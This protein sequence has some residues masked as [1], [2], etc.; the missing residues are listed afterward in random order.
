MPGIVVGVDGSDQSRAALRWAMHEAAQHHLPLTVITVRPAP[1][2]PATGIYWAVPDLADNSADTESA[3][4]MVREFVDQ[5]A[6]ELGEAVPDVTVEVTTGN[7]AEEL[8]RA[9]RD[10][11]MLVV[12]SRG[13][14]GF[15]RLLLGSVSSQVTHHA[16]SPVVVVPGPREASRAAQPTRPVT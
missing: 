4:K 1:V 2:R 7:I 13:A 11:D 15:G 14:G 16:A 8:V 6:G 9:S 3:R 12:G 10:A 5:V